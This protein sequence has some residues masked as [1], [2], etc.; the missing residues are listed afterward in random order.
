MIIFANDRNIFL[1]VIG[2]IDNGGVFEN[3]RNALG[4]IYT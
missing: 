2:G 4:Y 1:E 3:F